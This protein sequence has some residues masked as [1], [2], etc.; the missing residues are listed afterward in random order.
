MSIEL[1]LTGYC[2]YPVRWN[3]QAVLKYQSTYLTG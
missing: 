3:F 2:L 1:L